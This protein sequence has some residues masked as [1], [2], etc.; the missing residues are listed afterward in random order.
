VGTLASPFVEAPA[1][2]VRWIG[3]Y[4]YVALC[5]GIIYKN[6]ATPA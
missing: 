6:R 5:G 2:L 4:V 3:T 1:S